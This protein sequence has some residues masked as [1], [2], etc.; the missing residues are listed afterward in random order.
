[1]VDGRQILVGIGQR[2]NNLHGMEDSPCGGN[3]KHVLVDMIL[4]SFKSLAVDFTSNSDD[5]SFD[6]EDFDMSVSSNHVISI[7]DEGKELINIGTDKAVGA[8]QIANWIL[9]FC[10]GTLCKAVCS[11]SIVCSMQGHIPA[12][13][14]CT[15]T[16]YYQGYP[17]IT[18]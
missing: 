12:I 6:S 3:M 13:W 8:D 14:N 16:T 2:G 10:A 15:N 17:S 1:M 7:L 11:Y 18:G 9:W 4:D 5:D